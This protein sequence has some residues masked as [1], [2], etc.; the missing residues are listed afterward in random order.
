MARKLR[1]G[2]VGLGRVFDLNV[3]GYLDHPEAEVSALC[4]AD[5]DILAR[6]AAEHPGAYATRDFQAL[7]RHDLDLIE[8]LTPHPLHEAMTAAALAAGSHVSVQKPMAMTLAECDRM[9]EA[10]AAS[11]KRL[12]VFENFIFYPPLVR[13][14]ELMLK[15]AIGRPLHFRMKAVMADRAHAWPVP[16]ATSRWRHALAAEGRGGPIVFDHGHHM[17]AVALWLF[18]EVRDGF[19]C[20]EQTETKAGVYDAPATLT[21]RH[22]DPPVHGMWDVS[23][24]LKMTL[25]TDYYADAERFEIQGEEGVIQVTRCSDRMLDEPALT[26]YRDGEVRAFHNLNADWGASFALSTRHFLDVLAGR[27]PEEALT[28]PQGR[29]VIALYDLFQRSNAEGRALTG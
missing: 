5:S 26:L 10:A 24:A 28:A 15:G 25:R 29:R 2:F 3:R 17:M 1:V 11:G 12:K 21:W 8:I 22:I 7:L 20:I 23:L 27:A 14:R 19:A 16:D 9:I 4:D 18:G 6:R 13:A